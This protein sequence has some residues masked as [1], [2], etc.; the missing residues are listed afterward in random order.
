MINLVAQEIEDY[1]HEHT[2]KESE[3]FERLREETYREMQSPQMQVGR[4]EGKFL[5]MLVS[6]S[7]ARRVL[8]SAC[9]PVIVH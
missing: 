7:Y 1:A 2:S 5:K 6:L 9:S 4:I 8:E 3:L